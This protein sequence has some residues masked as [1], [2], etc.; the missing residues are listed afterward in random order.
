MGYHPV[1]AMSR[2][3]LA[4]RLLLAVASGIAAVAVAEAVFR[5]CEPRVPAQALI[6]GADGK[7]KQLGEI[8]GYLR[9]LA[10]DRPHDD[11]PSGGLPPGVK[12]RMGYVP[13][14]WD[15][16]DADGC[17][18]VA[19]NQLGFRDREFPLEKRPGEFRVLAIGDSFTF[20]V[21]LPLEL[22]WP[23]R[24]EDLLRPD[25]RGPVEVVNAGF[26]GNAYNPKGYAPWLASDGMRLLPDLVL[27]GFC[28]NDMSPYV[29]MLSYP[30]VPRTPVLGGWSH[31][32][33][34][35]VRGL[36]QRAARNE[37]RSALLE[38]LEKVRDFDD[39]HATQAGLQ[40]MQKLTAERGV[41]FSVVVFPMLTELERQPFKRLHAMVRE[42]C[43]QNG[44]RCLDLQDAFNGFADEALWVHPTD[45]HPNHVATKIIAERVRE[46]LLREQLV[47]K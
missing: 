6:L 38:Q 14:T 41:P 18:E 35:I 5:W 22:T 21:G 12:F 33:D 25:H 40:A 11:L 44:I 13:R 23:Q 31:L 32:L 36:R 39:W 43:A 29:P 47:P 10:G 7:P 2:S 26:A 9:K 17:V 19:I 4:R 16:Y 46:W 28:L 1:V 8:I 45:Q 3:V 42:F 30:S 27:V 34:E 24:L 20:G 37:D 15:Y